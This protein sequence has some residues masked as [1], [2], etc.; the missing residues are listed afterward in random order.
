M[1]N[2]RKQRLLSV[3]NL[4]IS[5]EPKTARREGNT[6]Y[7]WPGS[8]CWM[9]A[10]KRAFNTTRRKSQIGSISFPS[11]VSSASKIKISCLESADAKDRKDRKSIYF[12]GPFLHYSS[13]E[14]NYPQEQISAPEMERRMLVTVMQRAK[15]R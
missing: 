2:R 1:I 12:P 5:L 3:L 8:K 4:L 6:A 7:L 9:R 14:A 11:G 13:E 10:C 15:F